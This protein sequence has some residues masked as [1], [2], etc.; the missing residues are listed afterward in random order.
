MSVVDKFVRRGRVSAAVCT[1]KVKKKRAAPPSMQKRIRGEGR[2][3]DNVRRG[4]DRAG[5]IR[6]ARPGG[7]RGGLKERTEEEKSHGRGSSSEPGARGKGR[8]NWQELAVGG[9]N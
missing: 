7:P 8:K 3:E 9:V 6:P 1:E 4:V 5:R 2:A